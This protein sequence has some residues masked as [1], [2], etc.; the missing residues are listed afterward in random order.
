[1]SMF[2]FKVGKEEVHTVCFFINRWIGQF[3]ATIDEKPVRVI[4]QLIIG[5]R[6]IKFEVGE[7]ERHKIRITWKIPYFGSFR[8]LEAKVFVDENFYETYTF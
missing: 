6:E 8:K 5:A 7:K 3:K 4:Y 2:S 1:M